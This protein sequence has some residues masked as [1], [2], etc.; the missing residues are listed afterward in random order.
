[1][2][3]N[4]STVVQY[5]LTD[6][7]WRDKITDS[8]LAVSHVQWKQQHREAVFEHHDSKIH[9]NNFQLIPRHD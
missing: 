5:E 4:I 6:D 3:G 8:L 7:Q 2:A 1:M 9:V